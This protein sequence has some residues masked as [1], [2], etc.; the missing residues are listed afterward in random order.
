MLNKI[1]GVV[2]EVRRLS[3]A[4]VKDTLITEFRIEM[5]ELIIKNVQAIRK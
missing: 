4:A 2:N 3:A 5:R 1:D